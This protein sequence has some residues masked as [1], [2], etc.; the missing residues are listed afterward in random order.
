MVEVKHTRSSVGHHFCNWD[1]LRKFQT[2]P[3][4]SKPSEPESIFEQL[5]TLH[6]EHMRPEVW[7]IEK[8]VGGVEHLLGAF[9]SMKLCKR[10]IDRRGLE[11]TPL[12]INYK[13][14][15]ETL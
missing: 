8:P 15:P 1:C 7:M 2:F 3:V 14:Q 6:E 9:S 11:G 5:E 13:T 12:K 10:E 4:D